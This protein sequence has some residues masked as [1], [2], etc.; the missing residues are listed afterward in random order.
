MVASAGILV[1][2]PLSDERAPYMIDALSLP[3]IRHAC[4]GLLSFPDR[5]CLAVLGC[6]GRVGAPRR[7]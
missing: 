7:D 2:N 5:Q 3:E 4:A 1:N 6:P